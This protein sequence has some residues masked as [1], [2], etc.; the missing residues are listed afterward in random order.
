M[1]SEKN[2]RFNITIKK[3]IKER[4]EKLIKNNSRYSISKIIEMLLINYLNFKEKI[5]K[6]NLE[7]KDE[8]DPEKKEDDQDNISIEDLL[9]SIEGL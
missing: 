1:V 4:L 5:D 8:K 7:K 2:I 6:K 3:E 9:K